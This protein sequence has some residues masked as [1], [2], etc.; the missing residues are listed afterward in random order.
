MSLF[1]SDVQVFV[2][3]LGPQGAGKSTFLRFLETGEVKKD[4]VSTLGM[5]KRRLVW[6]EKKIEE[7]FK[8]GVSIEGTIDIPGSRD[9]PRDNVKIK[10]ELEEI[11]KESLDEDTKL[12]IFYFLNSY[13]LLNMRELSKVVLSVKHDV[14]WL[15][16]LKNKLNIPCIAA[17]IILSHIDK[18]SDM[19]EGY[20]GNTKFK[21]EL[22]SKV[23]GMG[24]VSQL[25]N[26]LIGECKGRFSVIPLNLLDKK[27][28]ESYVVGDLRIMMEKIAE[29]H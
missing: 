24:I 9:E 29:D 14:V 28:L 17:R 8:V 2:L 15:Y 23:L 19:P 16:K 12:V 21:Q 7:E 20:E 10:Q 4:M 26:V 27:Q 3:V 22:I 11:L 5:S 1:A 6:L 25:K 18:I 13:E